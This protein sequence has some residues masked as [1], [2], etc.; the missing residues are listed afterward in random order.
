[1]MIH[2]QTYTAARL[3]RSLILTRKL[4]WKSKAAMLHMNID[5]ITKA[6]SQK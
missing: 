3:L 1:M 2:V 6:I 4:K 5:P